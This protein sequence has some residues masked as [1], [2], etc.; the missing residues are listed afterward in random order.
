MQ[1]RDIEPRDHPRESSLRAQ[2]APL[3]SLLTATQK[4]SPSD[5]FY[6]ESKLFPSYQARLQG[7]SNDVLPIIKHL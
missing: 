3:A 1:N 4:G 6:S 5:T 2:C 7:Q